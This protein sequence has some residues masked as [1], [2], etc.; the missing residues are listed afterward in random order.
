MSDAPPKVVFDCVIFAQALINDAG[1]AGAC[2]ELLAVDVPETSSLSHELDFIVGMPV[3]SWS[4]AG[5]RIQEEHRDVHVAVLGADELMRA[6]DEWKILLTDA[7]H[8][9]CSLRNPTTRFPHGYP[10]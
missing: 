10:G 8:V 1:P 3:W 2:L 5:Q 6:A 7:V 4:A 9:K